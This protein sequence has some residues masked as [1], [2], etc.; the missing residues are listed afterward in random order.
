MKEKEEKKET[1]GKKEK[2]EKGEDRE[3]KKEEIKEETKEAK[4]VLFIEACDK[5]DQYEVGSGPRVGLSLKRACPHKREYVMKSYRF[6][7]QPHLLKKGKNL[8]VLPL[9]AENKPK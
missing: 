9:V 3:E 1:K 8:M 5:L 6:F 2:K 7:T 4:T